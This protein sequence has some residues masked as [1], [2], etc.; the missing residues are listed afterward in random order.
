M[1]MT[2]LSNQKLI[3]FA[4]LIGAEIDRRWF[5]RRKSDRLM[6][7]SSVF[8]RFHWRLWLR[9]QEL[10]YAL[11]LDV[12]NRLLKE[13]LIT[14]GTATASLIHAREVFSSAIVHRASSVILVHNHPSG[15]SEPSPEDQRITKQ[16]KKS[17]KLIGIPLLDHIIIGKHQYYSDHL[18]RVIFVR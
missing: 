12:K 2:D 13:Q 15:D 16:L 9:R 18:K 3:E 5:D 8:M 4:E 17:G 11:Y 1:K 14:V 7:A 10:L 6:D